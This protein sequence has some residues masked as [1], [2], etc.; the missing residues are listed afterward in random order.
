MFRIEIGKSWFRVRTW[1]FAVGLAGVAVLPVVIL[2]TDSQASGGPALFDFIRHSGLVAPVTAIALIQ[3]FF[4]PLGTSLLAGEALAGEASTG[5]L[6]YLVARP[7]GRVRLVLVK[8]AAVMTQ[9]GASVLWVMAAALVAGLIAFGAGPL[10]T[11]SGVA[12]SVGPGLAR[13][14]LAGGYVLLGMAGLAAIGVFFSTLTDS[15]PGATVATMSVAIASQIVDS[16]PAARFLHPFL[17]SHRWLAF[18]DLFRSPVEWHPMVL[19]AFTAL[20]YTAIFLVAALG[21]FTRKDV[22]S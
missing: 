2:A 22:V 19:G 7:V 17:I 9:L 11:L 20:A 14:A 6:R 12:L 16:L 1:F 15:G 10:P 18:V 13:V 8:Y 5:T 4:L 3:P 21:V